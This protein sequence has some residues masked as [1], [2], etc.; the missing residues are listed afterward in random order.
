M[1]FSNLFLTILISSLFTENSLSMKR[2]GPDSGFFSQNVD[3]KSQK[4]SNEKNSV[5]TRDPIRYLDQVNGTSKFAHEIGKKIYTKKVND[6][7]LEKIDKKVPD[8]SIFVGFIDVE[9]LAIDYGSLPNDFPFETEEIE[10][11]HLRY[12]INGLH[13]AV[14]LNDINF[15]KDVLP[16][17]DKLNLFINEYAKVHE[18]DIAI[19]RLD[20]PFIK[21]SHI[22]I[23]FSTPLSL[24]LEPYI[25]CLETV[26]LLVENGADVNQ[27]LKTYNPN[28][29][30]IFSLE[31]KACIKNAVDLVLF[32]LIEY[33]DNIDCMK[34]EDINNLIKIAEILLERANPENIK[35][36]TQKYLS[37]IDD[38][39]LID[40]LLVNLLD[41]EKNITINSLKS[42]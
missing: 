15:L 13:L 27:E 9:F 23:N 10:K 39:E 12:L 11:E 38:E 3:S 33:I 24:A 18:L 6:Y 26:K 22:S 32:K 19:V 35:Y 5:Y 20:R 4:T 41:F 17:L 31:D 14:C 21:T 7:L 42:L 28:A 36:L 16:Q 40:K 2:N 34:E 25:P 1:K 8:F 37:E 30:N 29:D